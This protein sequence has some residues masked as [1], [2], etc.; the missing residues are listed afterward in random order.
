MLRLFRTASVC[1]VAGLA[2]VALHC[3]GAGEPQVDPETEYRVDLRAPARHDRTIPAPLLVVLHGHEQSEE[4]AVGLWN[5]R[6]FSDPDFIL[7]SVRGPF[8]AEDGYAWFTQ[9]REVSDEWVVRAKRSVKA[10]E[11]RVLDAVAEAEDSFEIDPDAIYVLGFSQG[12]GAAFCVGLRNPDVFAGIAAVAGNL[13]TAI[14]DVGR[15]GEV[16][17]MAAFI[18]LGR[19]EGT[20]AVEA[21]RG[22]EALL[23][24]LGLDIEVFLHDGGHVITPD[25]VHEMQ[26]FFGLGTGTTLDTDDSGFDDL[27]SEEGLTDFDLEGESD[28]YYEEEEYDEY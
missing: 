3:G 4:Q 23:R 22:S 12:A 28:E 11:D 18:A 15:L 1:V 16:D 20:R 13:D 19:G 9:S 5:G 17:D 21:V 6:F 2:A 7:A 25:I 27:D 14:V 26:D 24:E 10:I 8:E